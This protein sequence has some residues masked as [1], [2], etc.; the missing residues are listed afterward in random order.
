[1]TDKTRNILDAEALAKTKPGVRIIN[2]ARGGLVDEAALA[3]AIKSGHVAGAG[4]D[5]FETEPATEQPAV[6]SAQRRLHPAPGR[7]DHG[8]AG[9]RGAAGGR[10]DVGL[11]DP[12]AVS[13]AINMPS[14]TAEEAPILKPFIRLADVLGS[15]AGQVTESPIKEIEILYDGE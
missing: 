6:R 3:E 4:F 7:L 8:S 12:G 1:M 10:A 9:K 14:I 5:V 13:N 2:C 15:F 11:P